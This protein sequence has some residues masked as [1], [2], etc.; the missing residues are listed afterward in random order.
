[1]PAVPTGP[2][3]VDRIGALA[4]AEPE[5]IIAL[6][7]GSAIAAVWSHAPVQTEVCGLPQHALVLHLSGRTLV[8]K[9]RDGRLIGHRSRIGSVSLVPAVVRSGWVLSGHSRVAHL[10]LD[11]RSLATLADSSDGPSSKPALGDFFAQDDEVAAALIRLVLAQAR[12]GTFDEL[13]HDEVMAMLLRHL[14]RRHSADRPLGPASQ[15]LTLTSA[16]LR[17]LFAHIEARLGDRLC[18]A[19]LAALAHL[20]DDHFLRAFRAAVGQTP[21]Q[22]VL[23]RRIERAQ[24]L[25]E[26]TVL[27]IKSIAHAVGFTGPSH[28]A[29]AFRQRVGASPSAWR[30]QRRH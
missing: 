16:L 25:L 9:W 15:Q 5:Q 2:S 20:S 11:P 26:R 10:Y 24:Q 1:M 22:Y 7:E 14:L 21:H 4:R 28:F 17:R 29:A 27:P 6:R 18:L 30:G 19:E 23:A 13:A 12:A 3:P 8:E